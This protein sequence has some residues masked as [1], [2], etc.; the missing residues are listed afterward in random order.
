MIFNTTPLQGVYL[1]GLE[2]KEDSRGFFARV[3]CQKEFDNF[4][5][6][7]SFVQI[8]NSLSNKKGTLRGMH[9]QLP[10]AAEVK[11]VRCITGAI[12][13]VVLDLRPDSFTF[14]L[15]YGAELSDDNRLMMYIPPGCAH[16]FITLEDNAEV[17][18]LVNNYYSSDLERGIRYDDPTFSIC[19]PMAPIEISD[20]DK[21]HPNFNPNWHGLEILK[22]LL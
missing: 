13:D 19:W 3:F 5:I 17:L 15:Y 1:I 11:V 4:N 10:P 20:R 9:Y 6:L 22:G 21:S 8:N 2:K 7:S 12:Y 14:G 18:Y 16:G